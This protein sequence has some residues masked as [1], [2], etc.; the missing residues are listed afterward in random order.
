[1]TRG[2]IIDHPTAFT[3]AEM[4][5]GSVYGTLAHH[6]LYQGG[7]I[8]NDSAMLLHS[9]GHANREN[10]SAKIS[11]GDM[12]GTSG[13]Y[14]G[15]LSDAMDLVDEDLVDPENFKFFFN[16]VEFS[17]MELEAM[18]TAT[19]SDG[20]AWASM[21][22]PTSIILNNDFDRGEGWSYLRNQIRK[23]TA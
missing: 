4:G 10:K 18:L 16:Y 14:E 9:C 2:V 13:I 7:D 19:D 15:G 20:D 6:N 21:E 12:I 23:L 8:G 11:C 3:M 22:V 5:G 1:M 17:D